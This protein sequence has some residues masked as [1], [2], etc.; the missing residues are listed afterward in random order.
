MR[1]RILAIVGLTAGIFHQSSAQFVAEN[2]ATGPFSSDGSE[3]HEICGRPHI[4][5]VGYT[6]Q[7]CRCD[8]IQS[9]TEVKFDLVKRQLTNTGPPGAL[10][11]SLFGGGSEPF[12]RYNLRDASL[13]Y[14]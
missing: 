12:Q 3:C 8:E 7:D 10:L 11:T 2:S 9:D 5:V 6:I 4:A 14:H 1:S 13:T